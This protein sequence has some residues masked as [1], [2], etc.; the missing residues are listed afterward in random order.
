MKTFVNYTY[1]L[2]E[3][4]TQLENTTNNILDVI[5]KQEMLIEIVEKSEEKKQ[6][7][8]FINDMNKQ[9]EDETR[10]LDIINKR[11]TSLR[12][13]L[14]TLKNNDTIAEFLSELSDALGIFEPG[15]DEQ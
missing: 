3:L 7:V 6:F 11:I 9:I 1:R 4:F 13:V 12:S 8:E 5:K 10:Q 15:N 14:F 2:E